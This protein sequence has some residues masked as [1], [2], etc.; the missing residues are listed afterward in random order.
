MTTAMVPRQHSG[1]GNS[2]EMPVKKIG[3]EQVEQD[4]GVLP[5]TGFPH[6]GGKAKEG[7]RAPSNSDTEQ[8]R[9][10]HTTYAFGPWVIVSAVIPSKGCILGAFSG[11]VQSRGSIRSRDGGCTRSSWK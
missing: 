1:S 2:I 4:G 11:S 10:F 3:R 5:T 6:V 7:Q 8:T 9:A